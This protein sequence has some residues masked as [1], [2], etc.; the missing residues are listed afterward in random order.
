[1]LNVNPYPL[2]QD[3]KYTITNKFP[4]KYLT[5][6][7]FLLSEIKHQEIEYPIL[8]KPIKCSGGSHNIVILHNKEEL[9]KFLEKTQIELFYDNYI[10]ETYIRDDYPVELGI[11][12]EKM[13]FDTVGRIIEITEKEKTKEN[14]KLR[15]YRNNSIK[16]HSNLLNNEKIQSIFRDLATYVPNANVMRYDIRLKELNDLEKD[17]FII[18][19]MNGTMGMPLYHDFDIMW[20]FRRLYVGLYNMVTLQGYSPLHLPVAMYKSFVSMIMCDDYEN[21]FSLYS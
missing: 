18:L 19:E 17:D 14:E 16:S 2:D 10:V 5:K 7:H 13:P 20:L 9:N 1:M 21:L 11:L 4:R 12:Y 15:D 8:V 6:Q 3:N